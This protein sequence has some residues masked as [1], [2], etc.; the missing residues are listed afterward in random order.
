MARYLGDNPQSVI[1]A[2]ERGIQFDSMWLRPVRVYAK[3]VTKTGKVMWLAKVENQVEDSFKLMWCMLS[4]FLASHLALKWFERDLGSKNK[5]IHPV[6]KH[7]E[8][9]KVWAAFSIFEVPF[10]NHESHRTGH[11]PDCNIES[12][13]SVASIVNTKN[14]PQ[15]FPVFD[16][17]LK[18]GEWATVA[19]GYMFWKHPVLV[20]E[21][22]KRNKPPALNSSLWY[23][24]WATKNLGNLTDES[25]VRI[26]FLFSYKY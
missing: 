16:V 2:I 11:L 7:E 15:G 12:P 1:N 14:T 6:S 9:E 26:V 4:D 24:Q 21:H 10:G 22:W 19:E 20:L 17:I 23:G 8:W 18:N 25:E 13:W 3:A 5:C